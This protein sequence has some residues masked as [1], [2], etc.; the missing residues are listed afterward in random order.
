MVDGG[1]W[2]KRK[3]IMKRLPRTEKT[4]TWVTYS[5]ADGDRFFFHTKICGVARAGLVFYVVFQTAR[6][7]VP[8][9]FESI[10]FPCL[11]LFF[12][13]IDFVQVLFLRSLS[14]AIN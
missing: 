4:K 13:D 2:E 5:R 10:I 11:L 14:F 1:R 9:Q 6:I 12:I 7:H 3:I 8:A